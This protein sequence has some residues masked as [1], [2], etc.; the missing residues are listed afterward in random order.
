[1]VFFLTSVSEPVSNTEIRLID[2]LSH[3]LVVCWYFLNRHLW[4]CIRASFVTD[5]DGTGSGVSPIR[6]GAC[7]IGHDSFVTIQNLKI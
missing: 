5:P 1:M 6:T 2:T 4:L 7:L 3:D